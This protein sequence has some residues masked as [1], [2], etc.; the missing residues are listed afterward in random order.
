MLTETTNNASE[1]VPD[2]TPTDA[3]TS[4][5]TTSASRVPDEHQ[6]PAFVVFDDAYEEGGYRYAPGVWYFGLKAGKGNTP[7]ML[8]QAWVCS[9]LHVDAVT[10]DATDGSYGRLLRFKS[11]RGKWKTWAMP[12]EMLAGDGTDLRARLLNAGVHIDMHTRNQLPVYLQRSTPK[13]HL[14]CV[15]HTGW[16]DTSYRAFVLPDA[17]I[18]PKAAGVVY[19][20]EERDNGEYRT[21]GTLQGWQTGVAAMAVGNPMLVLALCTAFAGP[22]LALCHAESG[23]PHYVG[24]SSTGKTSLLEAACLGA[25]GE[26]SIEVFQFTPVSENS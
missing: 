25:F 16:S 11:A 24:G 26:F 3:P 14:Q 13:R 22:L 9:P 19:Q 12:M 23:G 8:T 1:A 2:T 6:R 4:A 18:G 17:V 10:T 20:S 15:L 21:G 5:P 7:P